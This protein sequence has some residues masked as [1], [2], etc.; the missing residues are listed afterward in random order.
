MGNENRIYLEGASGRIVCIPQ[1]GTRGC[2]GMTLDAEYRHRPNGRRWSGLNG[3]PYER[4]NAAHAVEFRDEWGYVCDCEGTAKARAA[5]EHDLKPCADAGEHL[6][7]QRHT[8]AECPTT[9][10]EPEVT[11]DQRIATALTFFVNHTSPL[12]AERE[13]YDRLIARYS[14]GTNL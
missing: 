6:R 5:R 10:P 7:A 4:M 13:E 12:T 1:D 9:D 3:E 2:A 11:D 8:R 14:Q